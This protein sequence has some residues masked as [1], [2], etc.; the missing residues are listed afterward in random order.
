M[1]IRN[2]TSAPI[3]VALPLGKRLH[4]APGG[5]GQIKP[6]AA[7]HPPVAKLI[8]SGDLEITSVEKSQ[9]DGGSNSGVGGSQSTGGG[10]LR[11][12]GDR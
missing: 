10:G 1:E 4:L 5:K 2:T 9:G 8:E 11:H 7:E 6:K 3:R 12:T